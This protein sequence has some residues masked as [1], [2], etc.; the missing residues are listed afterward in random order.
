MY[1]GG[2][3]LKTAPTTPSSF[4][5]HVHH[6]YYSLKKNTK[7]TWP[8]WFG[9]KKRRFKKSHFLSHFRYKISI[10]CLKWWIGGAWKICLSQGQPDRDYSR[11]GWEDLYVD[12]TL[13]HCLYLLTG[14]MLQNETKWCTWEWNN[15]HPKWGHKTP[16]TI[17]SSWKHLHTTNR[18]T[19]L[20][21]I[22]LHFRDSWFV[23]LLALLLSIDRS[24]FTGPTTL[25]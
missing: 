22:Y 21:T 6:I 12:S 4:V 10:I 14:E 19:V 7:K 16:A 1:H 9:K 23:I 24:V 13:D 25:I 11:N 17:F 15:S 20:Q 2:R 8:R 18:K 5:E 3:Q